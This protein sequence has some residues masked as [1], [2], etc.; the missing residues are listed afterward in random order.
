[1]ALVGTAERPTAYGAI[2]RIWR[3]GLVRSGFDAHLVSSLGDLDGRW[4]DHVIHH[5]YRDHFAGLSRPRAGKLVAVRTWDFGPF[6]RRWADIVRDVCDELWVHSRWTA[7]QAAAGGIDPAKVHVIPHGVD[8]GVL[9]P[10]GPPSPL[11]TP[12]E[13]GAGAGF[14]FL[15]VGAAV[16][17]KGVDV[18]L[19]AYARA[20]RSTDAVTLTIKDHTGDVFYEGVGL[21]E[22]IEAFRE[23]PGAPRL[24]YVDA[25]LDTRDLAALYRTC[26]AA[27]F[28]YRA[29]GFAMPILESMACGTPAIVPRFGAC[30]DFCDDDSAFFVPARRIRLP[31]GRNLQFNTLGFREEVEEVDFCEIDPAV[32]AAEM[33]RVVALPPAELERAGRAAAARARA[34]TWDAAIARICE[35]LRAA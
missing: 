29:E 23:R 11:A 25:Y 33:Q 6:P 19:D 7:E 2:N 28:P 32:L 4:Y 31:V 21:R 5:D 8:V 22:Q 1:V 14:T 15:F 12:G 30:L 20:F 13:P 34:F 27:V 18:L 24:V 26:D 16:A 10:H 3:D 35:R 9:T 17:R